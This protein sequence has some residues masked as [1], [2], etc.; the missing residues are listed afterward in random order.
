MY[1]LSVLEAGSPK[2]WCWQG[3]APSADK[4]E[5]PLPLQLLMV[6]CRT[7][8]SL[9]CGCVDPVSDYVFIQPSSPCL[10]LCPSFSLLNKDTHHWIRV[11]PNPQWPPWLHQ[12]RPHFQKRSH[13]HW[14]NTIQLISWNLF[15]LS[16]IHLA[17]VA[18]LCFLFEL[19]E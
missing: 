14:R 18:F 13:S 19:C 12:Q 15:C 8:S 9:A 11:Y 16:D 7:W 3:H 6:A 17:T 10:S 4:K 2:S 1:S 5:D